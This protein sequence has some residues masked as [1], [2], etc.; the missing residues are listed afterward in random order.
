MRY[1]HS[2]EFQAEGMTA[3]PGG[4]YYSSIQ[5]QADYRFLNCDSATLDYKDLIGKGDYL[6]ALMWEL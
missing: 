2:E 1:I 4:K 3:C 5:L 6:I